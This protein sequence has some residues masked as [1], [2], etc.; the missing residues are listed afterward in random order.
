MTKCRWRPREQA[1]VGRNP[2]FSFKF[3]KW[4]LVGLGV[5]PSSYSLPFIF[6]LIPIIRCW[7]AEFPSTP[8][9]V[10]P[11]HSY[12]QM[13]PTRMSLSCTWFY[14][15]QD[16][17]PQ[18]LMSWLQSVPDYRRILSKR[19]IDSEKVTVLL[20]N[21]IFSPSVSCPAFHVRVVLCLVLSFPTCAR[22]VSCAV[23]FPRLFPRQSVE[24]ISEL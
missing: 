12:F 6:K 17:T 22:P 11:L 18:D 14:S 15:L 16:F 2:H 5:Y 10:L 1:F 4:I 13:Y 23:G 7:Y 24:K 19:L 3:S 8:R 9:Q 21:A 20:P